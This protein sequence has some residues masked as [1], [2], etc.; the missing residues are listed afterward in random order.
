LIIL[1]GKL[2]ADFFPNYPQLIHDINQAGIGLGIHT[3]FTQANKGDLMGVYA[4]IRRQCDYGYWNIYEFN[5]ALALGSA[6]GYFSDDPETYL[7]KRMLIDKLRGFGTPEKGYADDLMADFLLAEQE[8]K[9]VPDVR[10]KFVVVCD[11]QIPYVFVDS[12]GE[13][14]VYNYYSYQERR[15]VGNIFVEGLNV[16]GEKVFEMHE[17]G[18][19]YDE[20]Q[21]DDFVESYQCL[22]LWARLYD[23]SYWDEEIDAI[24]PEYIATVQNLS[25]IWEERIK[26]KSGNLKIS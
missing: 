20:G 2:F 3:V 10:K 8:F 1:R 22:P 17:Q 4:L 23:G 21:E 15:G 14:S 25:V 24:K 5:H 9:K 16:V 18:P 11:T 19:C 12:N 7:R 6:R 13:L 26:E